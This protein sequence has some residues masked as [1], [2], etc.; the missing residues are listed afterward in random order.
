LDEAVKRWV[1][2]LLAIALVASVAGAAYGLRWRAQYQP[3]T[4]D[5]QFVEVGDRIRSGV[6]HPGGALQAGTTLI[7]EPLRELADEP[8]DESRARRVEATYV[9]GQHLTSAYALHNGGSVGITITGFDIQT[10]PRYSLLA[11]IDLRV[12]K[13]LA[14]GGT[15]IRHTEPFR[16][17][18]LRAGE[19]RDIVVRQR[20]HACEH[21]D[22]GSGNAWKALGVRYRVLGLNRHAGVPT[23]MY[24]SVKIAD[25]YNCP[26][27]RR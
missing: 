1:I 14:N 3:L 6:E 13:R 2:T 27:A 8:S 21:Y 20:M 11:F 9:D 10:P 16:P 23:P 24:V 25:D 17:F 12:G 5:A 18:T 4:I 19:A 26:H 22:R 15:S 7:S